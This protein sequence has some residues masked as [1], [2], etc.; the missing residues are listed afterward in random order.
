[1]SWDS[2][3]IFIVTTAVVCMTPGTAALLVVAQGMSHGWSR[4]YWAVAGI[5][6]ANS[7]YFALSATGLATLLVASSLAF[8]VIKWGGVAY[9]FYLGYSAIMSRSSAI[10]VMQDPAMATRGM[11]AFW[12][13]FVVELSNPKALLYFVALLPQFIDS[14][15]PVM[16]Q[17]LIFG[18]SCI[19]LDL[20]AYSIYGW[21][22]SKTKRFTANLVFVKISNRIAGSLLMFAGFA[23]ATLTQST[24]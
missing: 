23:M 22:G 15:K 4:S 13:A 9:L 12:Q 24:H 14:N 10:T 18:I 21:L 20:A 16:P 2:Y 3:W 1:M 7:L 19:V 8:L 6:L 5:T 11:A 17:M